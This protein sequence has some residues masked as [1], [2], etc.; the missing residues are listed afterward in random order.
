MKVLVTGASGALARMVIERLLHKGHTIIGIDRRP[1]PDAPPGVEM[2]RADVRKRPAEDV[3]RTRRPQALIHMA[4]VTHLTASLEERFRINLDGTRRLLEH[5]HD[6][7]VRQAIFVGRHTVYGAAADAPLYRTEAHPPLAASTLP[8]LADLVAADLF[9]GTAHWRWPDVA[10][11]VLRLVY[12]LGPSRRGTLS[13]FIGAQRVP[14]VM[15]F[16]PLFQ[17]MHEHDAADAIVVALEKKARGIFNVAGPPPVPL[18]VLCRATERR[19]VPIPEPLFRF[20]N[21]RRGFPPLEPGAVNHVKYPIVI[22][23]EAFREATGFRHCFDEVQT[24]EA[25]VYD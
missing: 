24:M 1:W 18:S 13:T 6:Y 17:L 9:A 5:C 11:V 22:S 16:D 20:V 8:A 19:R 10:T 21:G 25:Y 23:D 3:F 4:T 15:G 7:G 14:T 12:T 2:L